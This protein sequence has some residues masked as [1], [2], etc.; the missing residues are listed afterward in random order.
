MKHWKIGVYFGSIAL[1]VGIGMFQATA[2]EGMTMGSRANCTHDV[3]SNDCVLPN[4]CG[5]YNTCTTKESGGADSC[6]SAV[7]TRCF[8]S[9]VEYCNSMTQQKDH[10]GL[11]YQECNA[12]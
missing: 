8:N 7:S 4:N 6:N 1:A 5:T 10:A 9:T 11:T 12:E 3:Q 2:K